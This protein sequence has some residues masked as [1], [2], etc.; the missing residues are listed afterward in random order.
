[1]YLKVC[2]KPAYSLEYLNAAGYRGIYEYF[3]GESRYNSS[4]FGWAGHTEE[5][6]IFG[7]VTGFELLN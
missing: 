7:N 4:L 2:M 6:K 3:L 5:G 1:M